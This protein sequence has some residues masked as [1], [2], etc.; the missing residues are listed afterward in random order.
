MIFGLR[1]FKKKHVHFMDFKSVIKFFNLV[2]LMKPA[3]PIYNRNH[4]T[5]LCILFR[6]T[7]KRKIGG[8][9]NVYI[10]PFQQTVKGS[11]SENR[12]RF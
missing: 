2:S 11:P 12:F 9:T 7:L 3:K 1:V 5:E 10:F 8:P 4:N 6:T